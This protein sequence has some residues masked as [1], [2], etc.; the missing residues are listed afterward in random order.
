[1]DIGTVAGLGNS[2]FDIFF[3]QIKLFSRVNGAIG[4]NM[5]G[6]N[7]TCSQNTVVRLV[8]YHLDD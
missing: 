7:I 4:I 3:Y 8:K 6:T 5:F 1:M 2:G